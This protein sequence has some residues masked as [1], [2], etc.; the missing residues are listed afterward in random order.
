MSADQ[1]AP[2]V[3][4]EPPVVPQREGRRGGPP[5]TATLVR[6]VWLNDAM[7][8]L[9]FTGPDVDSLPDLVFTDH[10]VKILFPGPV[11]RTY[12]IRSLDRNTGELALDF[13][14]HGDEGLA[15]PWAANAEP[16]DVIEFRGPGGAYAPG[17]A[18]ETH[19]LVGDEAA[20][21]AI[22]A[23][24]ESLPRH[25]TATAVLEVADADH[26]LDV[27]A[28]RAEVVWVHRN[29]SPYGQRL[30][31]AVRRRPLP[32]GKLQVFVHGNAG[33][34]KDLRRLFFVELRLDRADVSIS[35]YWRTGQ[36]EDAWQSG[37]HDFVAQMEAEEAASLSS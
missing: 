20:I 30:A 36:N 5:R 6:K 13:V 1:P 31:E 32:E 26:Q 35:G 34:V 7:V 16:G 22:A 23:A 12:T 2:P 27:P 3:V 29:G 37:K 4:Q 11:T 14:V 24:L 25:A 9:F 33:M 17:E 21:P 28:D 10:Y 19:L 8:R 18:Y 15:G